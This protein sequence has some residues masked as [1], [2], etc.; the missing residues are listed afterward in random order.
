MSEVA[1]ELAGLAGGAVL[2]DVGEVELHALAQHLHGE[3]GLVDLRAGAFR[4]GDAHRIALLGGHE[5]P[6]AETRENLV[7]VVYVAV[8]AGGD[9]FAAAA[10]DLP[11]GGVAAVDDG[12]GVVLAHMG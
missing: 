10:G 4:E 3:V 5:L 9:E 6:F 2:H 1:L 11:L 7:D 8:D 12:Y